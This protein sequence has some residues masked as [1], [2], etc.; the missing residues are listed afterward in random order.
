MPDSRSLCIVDTNIIVDLHKGGVLR[1]LFGLPHV[2]AA[3]DVIVEESLTPPGPLLTELGLI[4]LEA[5]GSEVLEVSKL[6]GKH[7]RVSSNDLFALVL[8]RSRK[9]TLLTGDKNLRALAEADGL[10]VH[11][12]LWVLDELLRCSLISA[13]QAVASLLAMLRTGSRFPEDECQSRL[14]RWSKR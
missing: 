1:E 6:A 4:S 3:P 12:T 2:F 8:A 11:G 5:S 9:A 10:P 7:R 13:E 14:K